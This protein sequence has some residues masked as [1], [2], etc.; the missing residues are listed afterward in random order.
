MKNVNV[1]GH[2]FLNVELSLLNTPIIKKKEVLSII[3]WKTCG[4]PFLFFSFLSSPS[5]IFKLFSI[6]F[7][8]LDFAKSSYSWSLIVKKIYKKN[9][10]QSAVYWSSKKQPIFRGKVQSKCKFLKTLQSVY[11][12]YR[13]SNKM[14][15]KYL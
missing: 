4:G 1:H 2:V 5:C 13:V 12:I 14:C 6:S 7:F 3:T 9:I 15:Y 10:D 8:A 11:K